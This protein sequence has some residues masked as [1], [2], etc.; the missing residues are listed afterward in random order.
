MQ[1]RSV[2][3]GKSSNIAVIGGSDCLEAEKR[4]SS[5]MKSKGEMWMD[6]L[7]V[8]ASQLTTYPAEWISGDEL[9]MRNEDRVDVQRG[10]ICAPQC[11]KDLPGIMS[12]RKRG[13]GVE[14]TISYGRDDNDKFDRQSGHFASLLCGGMLLELSRGMSLQ[15]AVQ[16]QI[17][18]G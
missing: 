5:Q 15:D 10:L 3:Q 4:F 14:R 12:V 8:L 7:A 1:E 11:E 6:V 9:W 18:D 16:R 2:S 17:D 13:D